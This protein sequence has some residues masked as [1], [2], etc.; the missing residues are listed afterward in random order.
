MLAAVDRFELMIRALRIA[1]SSVFAE[2]LTS[3]APAVGYSATE[4]V[5]DADPDTRDVRDNLRDAGQDE[6]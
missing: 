2:S 3:A 6:C 1:G 5:D 4:P